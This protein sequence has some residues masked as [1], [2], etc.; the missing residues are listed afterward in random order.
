MIYRNECASLCSNQTRQTRVILVS[1]KE[2]L[3]VREVCYTVLCL[4]LPFPIPL[5]NIYLSPLLSIG[6]SVPSGTD[7]VICQV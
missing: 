6:P 2:A 3:C 4:F 5:S 1:V 7:C